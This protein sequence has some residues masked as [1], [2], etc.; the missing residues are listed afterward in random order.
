[1]STLKDTFL[2]NFNSAQS[3]HNK[4]ISISNFGNLTNNFNQ[5]RLYFI[6]ILSEVKI[7]FIIFSI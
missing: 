3:F 5:F 1:M 4:Y 2:N 6:N 7:F